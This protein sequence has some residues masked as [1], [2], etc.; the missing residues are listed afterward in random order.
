MKNNS[1]VESSGKGIFKGKK[2]TIGIDLGDRF[3]YYCVLDE[4]GE[5]LIEQKLPR[6]KQRCRKCS[7]ECRAAAWRWRPGRILPGSAGN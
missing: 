4:T 7:A 2:L 6:R 1:T 3:S 5:V